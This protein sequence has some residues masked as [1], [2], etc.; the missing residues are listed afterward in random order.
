M[1]AQLSDDEMAGLVIISIV[2]LMCLGG[3]GA[4][5]WAYISDSRKAKEL[6]A[7]K[8]LGVK[9][10]QLPEKLQLVLTAVAKV[11]DHTF[12]KSLEEIVFLDLSKTRHRK[13]YTCDICKRDLTGWAILYKHYS[14]HQ[15]VCL[16][17]RECFQLAQVEL[18]RRAEAS[19][20]THEAAMKILA[21]A[22]HPKCMD[23]MEKPSGKGE[24]EGKEEEGKEEEA[25]SCSRCECEEKEAA[26]G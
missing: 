7:W 8:K 18:D 15:A 14:T 12:V 2:I 22:L 26:K 20:P 9:F 16:D 3:A 19:K 1:L 24:E 10:E 25:C 6:A 4:V 11:R 23:G 21:E 13:S 5:V 17:P